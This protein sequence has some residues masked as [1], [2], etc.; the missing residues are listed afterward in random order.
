MERPHGKDLGAPSSPNKS[1]R[2][3]SSDVWGSAS[4]KGSRCGRW[5][6][7]RKNDPPGSGRRTRAGRTTPRSPLGDSNWLGSVFV[8]TRLQQG[9]LLRLERGQNLE[10]RWLTVVVSHVFLD[11]VDEGDNFRKVLLLTEIA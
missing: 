1:S 4:G 2:R 5:G 3:G 10:L 9:Q 11:C 8:R 6:I 7:P